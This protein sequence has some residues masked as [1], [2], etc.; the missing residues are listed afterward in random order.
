MNKALNRWKPITKNLKTKKPV[1]YLL[2][3]EFKNSRTYITNFD[4]CNNNFTVKYRNITNVKVCT[5]PFVKFNNCYEIIFFLF[6]HFILIISLKSIFPH[7]CIIISSNLFNIIQPNQFHVYEYS[8]RHNTTH[9]CVWHVIST[10]QRWL[11][12]FLS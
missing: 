6:I 10:W 8:N 2:P 3:T 1:Y 9:H 4:S 7:K 12:Y 11:S 5:L